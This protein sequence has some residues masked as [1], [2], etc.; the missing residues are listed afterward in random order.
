MTYLLL[1]TTVI[2]LSYSNGANDNFKGVATLYSCGALDYD[3]AIWTATI[4]TFAGSICSLILADQ[5]IASF[6]GQGLVPAPV[7]TE[8][9]FLVAVSLGAAATVMAATMGGF[10][11]STTHS[12][13]G[14]LTGAGL[15]AVGSE[16]NLPV[17]AN[18]FL[19]PLLFS[20]IVAILLVLSVIRIADHIDS[21]FNLSKPKSVCFG[22]ESVKLA[23]HPA[24]FSLW[25]PVFKVATNHGTLPIQV[26]CVNLE[27]IVQA[28]HVISGS[29]VSFA[30]GLNDTPK[31]VA[32]L[33]GVQALE[34]KWGMLLVA[35]FMALG[36]LINAR[37][38]AQTMS[39][40][41]T[42]I[43]QQHG[44]VS[45]GVTAFLVICA[46]RLGLPVSTTH[47]SVGS[48]FGVGVVS[49]GT[50]YRVI[51]KILVCWLITLPSAAALAA[52]V[53]ITVH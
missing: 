3:R 27:S 37:R 32:L 16:L 22:F 34:P 29:L 49:K 28:G 14:A 2:F 19:L 23:S 20:P 17:L 44:F 38:V 50:D 9:D 5:L 43:S 24:E 51:R 46:S 26:A 12:L 7:T 33:V 45:N 10:P 1:L 47:V 40:R 52:L 18:R 31:L 25:L 41:I 21:K 30:R 53:Y 13:I 48:L 15:I 35:L 39:K 42:L 36:G 8:T 4:T 11:I 6:S